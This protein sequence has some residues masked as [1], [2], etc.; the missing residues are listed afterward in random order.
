MGRDELIQFD[1]QATFAAVRQADEQIVSLLERAGGVDEH[2]IHYVE[3]AAHEI[4]TN[5]VEHAYQDIRDGVIFVTLRLIRQP[6]RTVEI[7]YQDQGRPF[8]AADAQPPNLD[9]PQEGGYGLFLAHSLMDE[10]SY[11]AMGQ[12]NVWRL[13]K[14]I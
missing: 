7:E 4:C 12:I 10:V 14:A 11:K 6:V 2:T 5:I 8:H 9:M 1:I 3:L 13:R